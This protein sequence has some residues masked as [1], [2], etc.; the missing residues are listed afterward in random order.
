MTDRLG[1]NDIPAVTPEMARRK[2]V[3]VKCPHC[4]EEILHNHDIC[5]LCRGDQ[6]ER[7]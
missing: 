1:P 4:G 3:M 7:D 6:P 2:G 5:P